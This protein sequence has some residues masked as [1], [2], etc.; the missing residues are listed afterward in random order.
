MY[1]NLIK[2]V[3]ILKIRIKIYIA[4]ITYNTSIEIQ[5]SLRFRHVS[6]FEQMIEPLINDQLKCEQR[7]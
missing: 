5:Q 2:N 3:F 4:T 6:W 1:L 7:R